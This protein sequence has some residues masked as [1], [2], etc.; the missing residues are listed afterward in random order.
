MSELRILI[1][2]DHQQTRES[3]IWVLSQR[4][5]EAFGVATNAEA[6]SWLSSNAVDVA[7]IDLHLGDE[8]GIDTIRLCC[9]TGVCCLA[10]T[11]SDNEA[12]VLGAIGAGACGY[13]LKDDPLPRLLSAI[14][15]AAEGRTPVS[16]GV[17]HHLLSRL[18]SPASD[19][20]LTKREQDVLVSLAG[21]LSYRECADSL[22][23]KVGTVQTYVKRI[24][25]KLGVST[26][27]EASSWAMRHGLIS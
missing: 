19:I 20:E 26:K 4:G 7:L 21:G 14:E 25:S 24:Y 8:S 13:L 5:V 18:R 6:K 10:L 1:V 27:T 17:A 15:D 2:E 9:E 11:I 16:S 22:N 23:L 3:M 12:D